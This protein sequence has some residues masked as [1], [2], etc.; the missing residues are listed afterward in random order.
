MCLPGQCWRRLGC[1]AS[2]PCWPAPQGSAADSIP[3]AATF[4]HHARSFP[5][6]CQPLPAKNT[7]GNAVTDWGK[8]P[9]DKLPQV[10]SCNT[11]LPSMVT[12]KDNAHINQE[13]GQYPPDIYAWHHQK[14][15]E[16]G[17]QTPVH[18]GAEALSSARR[19]I[20][21]DRHCGHGGRLQAAH[22][23]LTL[24]PARPGTPL[25]LQCGL[26]PVTGSCSPPGHHS[27]PALHLNWCQSPASAHALALRPRPPSVLPLV[28][29]KTQQTCRT[30]TA[31]PH[32]VQPGQKYAAGDQRLQEPS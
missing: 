12:G 16:Q 20:T 7:S 27:R 30:L 11:A 29:L 25:H 28:S 31:W 26:P 9:C 5:S 10:D 1:A 23:F 21:L 14:H 24:L 32:Q 8:H 4:A 19:V 15:H 6:F 3:Q 18:Q 2:C 17:Y 22:L 13:G